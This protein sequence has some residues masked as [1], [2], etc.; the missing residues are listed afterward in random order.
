MGKGRQFS[1]EF[2][3][4]VALEAIRGEKTVAELSSQFKVHATQ[5][6]QW[7]KQAL[8]QLPEAFNTKAGRKKVIE[9]DTVEGLYAKIG[10]LEIEND[11]LKK[12]V[13]RD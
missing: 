3:A 13:Y 9:D 8:A 12:T 11:F 5:I 6:S 1:T 4:K 10:R 7:K 2:K